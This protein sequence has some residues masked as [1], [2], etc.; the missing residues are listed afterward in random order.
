MRGGTLRFQA[1]YMRRICVPRLDTIKVTDR[2]AL[3]K[4]F[5]ARDTDKATDVALRVYGLPASALSV[6]S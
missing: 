5:E 6:L 2:T 3:S 1:Q 4:S